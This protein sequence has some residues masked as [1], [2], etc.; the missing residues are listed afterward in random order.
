MSKN[1]YTLYRLFPLPM[2]DS[3]SKS[4][5]LITL[6][7][8]IYYLEENNEI[9]ILPQSTY[10]SKDCTK[11]SNQIICK[12]SK[13]TALQPATKCIHKLIKE[14]N[15]MYCDSENGRMENKQYELNKTAVFE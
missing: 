3:D 12:I 14:N 7:E 6:P 10:D 15:Q 1:P 9:M 4:L 13:E 2:F 5:L 8:N 11:P